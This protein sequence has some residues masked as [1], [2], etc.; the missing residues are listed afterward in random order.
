MQLAR[1]MKLGPI[2]QHRAVA[3]EQA[4]PQ[5]LQLVTVPRVASQ[6]GAPAQFSAPAP[7]MHE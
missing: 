1:H 3:P 6:S 5:L 2:G 7:H 4:L